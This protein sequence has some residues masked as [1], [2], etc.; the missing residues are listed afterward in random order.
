MSIATSCRRLAA[1]LADLDGRQRR[2]GQRAWA[3]VPTA[4]DEG[5]TGSAPDIR[6]A[7]SP[8]SAR[9][10]PCQSERTAS[11]DETVIVV[12]GPAG[13]GLEAGYL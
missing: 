11:C 5:S 13:T 4:N 2:H 7:A 1:G 10:R 8:A 3:A 12:E 9:P 6:R